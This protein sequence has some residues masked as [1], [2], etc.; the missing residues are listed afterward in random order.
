MTK[1]DYICRSFKKQTH[2]KYESY[3]INAIW[4]KLDNE[5]VEFVTQQVVCTK[6]GHKLFDLYF[7]QIQLAVEVNE[8]YHDNDLQRKIDTKRRELIKEAIQENAVLDAV[9]NICIKDVN[10]TMNQVQRSLKEVNKDIDEIVNEIQ[11]K[12]SKLS[13]KHWY[14]T[15]EE[16][17][18]QIKKR[19]KL[20]SGDHFS[21]LIYEIINLVYGQN[22]TNYGNW[23]FYRSIINPT[24]SQPKQESYKGWVNKLE[25]NNQDF[26]M[27]HV[28][29]TL[30]AAQEKI[31]L[32]RKR[33]HETV[34]LFA[35]WK[36]SLGVKSRRF[37]GVY[38][39]Q[40]I[41]NVNGVYK[42]HWKLVSKELNIPVI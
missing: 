39:L 26:Y 4:Q 36:D 7:P 27:N 15:N 20:I 6:N 31:D 21:N 19:G 33:G 12:F 3:V 10:I 24:L 37:M 35:R 11:Q 17:A 25:N 30:K 32:E 2:K 14:F 40:G 41:V 18:K 1:L 23:S 5:E 29:G 28:S 38:E 34:F 16:K 13:D 22:K 8:K 42:L 9:G